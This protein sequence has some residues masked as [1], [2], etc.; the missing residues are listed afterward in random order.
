[1]AKKEEKRE[2]AVSR[3]R[4][5]YLP[6]TSVHHLEATKA[7]RGPAEKAIGRQ[8]WEENGFEEI[9]AQFEEMRRPCAA[10]DDGWKDSKREEVDIEGENEQ[11]GS[12]KEK[13][14]DRLRGDTI[15]SWGDPVGRA[16]E[17]EIRRQSWRLGDCRLKP[18]L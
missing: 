4:G 10:S 3:T 13:N 12:K 16:G 8:Q 18:P 2:R 17:T 11:M 5:I 15:A 1:M 14:H 6:S 7:I 9:G